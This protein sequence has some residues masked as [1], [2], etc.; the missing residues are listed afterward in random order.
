MIRERVTRVSRIAPL[1]SLLIVLMASSLAFAASPLGSVVAVKKAVFQGDYVSAKLDL[2]T[3]PLTAT[4]GAVLV[5]SLYTRQTIFA[6]VR[7]V[8]SKRLGDWPVGSKPV[9]FTFTPCHEAAKADVAWIV[10]S[11]DVR[12]TFWACP[13]R[14]VPDRAARRRW[15]STSS[16]SP[17]RCRGVTS[18][19]C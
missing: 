17:R 8:G 10:R 3:F 5:A 12:R 9:S 7:L 1:G 2:S 15:P 19:R 6:P 4:K 16:V 11:L 13:L 18:C 14:E